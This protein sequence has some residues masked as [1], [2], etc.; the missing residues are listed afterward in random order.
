MNKKIVSA[1]VI[2]LLAASTLA[3]CSGG[4]DSAKGT[5]EKDPQ[6]EAPKETPKIYIYQ[7]SGAL[8]QKP[9]GSVPAALEEMKK[10]YVDKL[11]IEPIAIV[12][13]KGAADE[14]LNLLLGSKDEIDIFQGNWDQYASKGAIIPLN[15][16]LDKYGQD[17]KKAWSKEAWDYMTD[18]DGKIWGIPRG[19]PSV[20]YPIWI[21]TDWLKKLNLQQPATLVELEAVLK[22]FKEQDPDGNGKDDTIPMI[23]DLN[24]IKNAFVGGFTEN[25]NSN[26]IDPADKKVK[27]M[28]LAPG[29]KD[30][31]ATM[32]DWYQKGYIYKEAF[33]KFDPLELLKTNRVGSSSMWYSRITLLFP[34]I[35]STLNPEA[36]Y[37]IVRNMEGP[38]GKLMTASPGSTA[39]MVIT[40]KAMHPDAVMK[41]VNHQ[42]QDVPTNTLTAA[43]GTNWKYLDD[44]K[45]EIEMLNKDISYAGEFM[46]S[47]GLA[48]E[49]KYAF[50]DPVKKL[51]ADYLNH[52]ISNIASAKMPID[53]M[54]TY[55]KKMLQEK[56]PTL[57]DI[58]RLRSEELVK[59]V[60]GARPLAEYDKFI[61]QLYKAGLDKWI[62]EYTRQY[63]EL[64]K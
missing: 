9:E 54:I 23:T 53:A 18:K 22:A 13:P 16:L 28:E 6:A 50:R 17:I 31:V 59:F 47:L 55:D 5:T 57:G 58:D 33:G 24:G 25:G 11:N 56:I 1:S 48:T 27:P 21:R 64:K 60:T 12:P 63:N 52:E 44:K 40:K 32:A 4:A 41:F 39:A 46:V 36:N 42:Y 26:W 14:K 37:E 15:D 35:Q 62:E 7:N 51:H 49:T 19:V 30:F 3:A 45:F 8:N 2:S 29:F 43:F 10:M 20:H 61:D 34:Q 38:K